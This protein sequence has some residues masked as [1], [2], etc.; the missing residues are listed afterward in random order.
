MQGRVDDLLHLL[1]PDRRL[2]A[3]ARPNLDR[4]GQA[5]PLTTFPPPRDRR[6]GH[7][8]LLRDPGRRETVRRHQQRLRA[9]HI[10]TVRRGL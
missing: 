9:L 10:I 5:I 8:N 1:R 2:A 6:R 7:A 4:A 3:P